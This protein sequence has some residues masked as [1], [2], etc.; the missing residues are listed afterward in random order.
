MKLWVRLLSHWQVL[1]H[2]LLEYKD[3]VALPNRQA[4]GN[5]QKLLNISAVSFSCVSTNPII[6]TAQRSAADEIKPYKR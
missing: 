6:M 5:R 2:P 4:H 1:H 3:S